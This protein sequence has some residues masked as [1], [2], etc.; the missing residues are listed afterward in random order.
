MY[1]SIQNLDIVG[2]RKY[3]SWSPALHRNWSCWSS[4]A[5]TESS[6]T[7][8]FIAFVGVVT[9][10]LARQYVQSLHGRTAKKR[11]A[12]VFKYTA[13]ARLHRRVPFLS[14][15]SVFRQPYD[16][17]H[18]QESFSGSE[19]C[20][21]LTDLLS[22]TTI[23][24]SSQHG[25]SVMQHSPGLS[26]RGGG[27]SVGGGAGGSAYSH[28]MGG[29]GDRSFSFGD[30][31]PRTPRDGPA[32]SVVD[33]DSGSRLDRWR[34]GGGGR[35]DFSTPATMDRRRGAGTGA[36]AGAGAED[37]SF[38]ALLGGSS[39]GVGVSGMQG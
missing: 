7:V 33:T 19:A 18:V 24:S 8:L 4:V 1:T 32:R 36:G 31:T 3:A 27:A 25:G 34:R 35:V 21:G 10:P 2:V 5:K 9:L 37:D 26:Q 13:S 23:S 17:K 20:A 39:P 28:R 15:I 38:D 6:R 12:V 30:E 29:G 11:L 14:P 22:K 16:Y